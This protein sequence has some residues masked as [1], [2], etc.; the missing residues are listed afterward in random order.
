MKA[1]CRDGDELT[2]IISL[3][4]IIGNNVL[5]AVHSSSCFNEYGEA[6]ENYKSTFI[7]FSYVLIFLGVVSNWPVTVAEWSKA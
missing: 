7:Q 5:R 1:F 3:H 6:N 2:S 4:E